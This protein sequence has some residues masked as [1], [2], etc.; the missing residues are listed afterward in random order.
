MAVYS[1]SVELRLVL[2]AGSLSTAIRPFLFQ[3]GQLAG[4]KMAWLPFQG[5]NELRR[6]EVL[7]HLQMR[8][9]LGL[10]SLWRTYV[11]CLSLG[12]MCTCL[13]LE[14]HLHISILEL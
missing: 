8:T 1:P 12:E 3:G 13:Q 2:N 9:L 5:V 14:M 6:D 11:S 7:F 10:I 4:F